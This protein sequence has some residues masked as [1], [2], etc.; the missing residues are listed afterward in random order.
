VVAQLVLWEVAAITPT[1]PAALVARLAG[2]GA[3]VAHEPIETH[4]YLAEWRVAGLAGG[5]AW[6]G[7]LE[8]VELWLERQEAREEAA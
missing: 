1:P 8:G 2:L 6:F 7:T 3:T 4:G 5:D